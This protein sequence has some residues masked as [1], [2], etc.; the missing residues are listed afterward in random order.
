LHKSVLLDSVLSH[1][2][3]V[4]GQIV[5]DATVGSGGHSE[6]ILKRISP[7]GL[8]IGL[9]QDPEALK[10]AAKRLEAVG[11]KFVLKHFNFRF[12]DEALSSLNLKQVNA[13]LLDVGVS[14][15]QLQASD[16]GFSFMREGPLD[17]RMDP[18]QDQTAEHLIYGL[19]ERELIQIF[20]ELGEERYAGRIARKI[21]QERSKRSIKTTF[22]LKKI[23]E[24]TVPSAYRFGRIHPA[25]RIFQALRIA[26]NDELNALKEALPKAFGSLK[27]GGRLAVISFHSLEDRI[28]K[29]YFVHEKNLG[30]GKIMTKKPIEATEDE[31]KNNP[32]SRSAKLRVIERS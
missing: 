26:V 32:R 5:L 10:R 29:Q 20:G 4:Q 17:M 2:N 25:T 1:L 23:V 16:R 7:N 14:S 9:D 3:L 27:P 11:G 30:T 22:D 15:D 8:L 21:V 13:V 31:L 12:L 19:S 24:E 18:T 6:T 28:V